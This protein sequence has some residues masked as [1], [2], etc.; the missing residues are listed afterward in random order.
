MVGLVLALAA[1]EASPASA[2]ITVANT[3]DSGAGSLRQAIATAGPGETI[4]LPASASHYSAVS[5]QLLIDKSLTITGAGARDTVID[6]M[7]APHRVIDITAGPVMISGVTVTGAKEAPEDGTG[8][9]IEGS[10]S[11]ALSRVSVSGN[12]VKQNSSGGGIESGG[13]TTLTID[14]STIANNVGYNGGGLDVDGTTLITDST[15]AGNHGGDLKNNGDAG[16]IENGGSLTLINDTIVGNE[17]FNGGGCGGAIFGSATI[18]NTIVAGNLGGNT[19]DETTVPS[20]CAS[21]VTSTG[22]NLESEGGGCGFAA[23]GGIA[24]AT[25]LLAPLANY[26]GQTDTILPLPGSPAIDAAGSSGCPSADQRGVNRPLGLGCD[27]GSV[28]IGAPGAST[29]AATAVNTT[30]A[31]LAGAADEDPAVATGTV[32]FQYGTSA[33]YGSQTAAQSLAAGSS[34]TPFSAALTDL[35]PGTVYHFRAVAGSVYGTAFGVDR[36]F[37]TTVPPR[38]IGP[39]LSLKLSS[40]TQSHARWRAGNALASVS[41]K[42]GRPPLGTSFSVTLSQGATLRLAF[43]QQRGGRKVKGKCLAPSG[44]N[45]GKPRCKR[46]LARGVLA[47]P[48]KAGANKIGF[49]GRVSRKV[50]L[51]PGSYTVVITAVAAGGQRSSPKRLSFTIVP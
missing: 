8:I 6:A 25:P 33:S 36:T 22:P 21:A 12:S 10:V 13:G 9:D 44:K 35:A 18:E 47:V 7:G 45:R 16:G 19:T 1:V 11:V 29:G 14:A 39:P 2:T 20:D 42:R 48:G 51:A 46:S 30:I 17:C 41:R 40:V 31:T 3:N 15:I 50:K 26:G 34:A 4:V 24:T 23:H 38:F 28:E 27:I 37:V 32:F 5:A 49:Q 43:L